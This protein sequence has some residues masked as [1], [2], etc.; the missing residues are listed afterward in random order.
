MLS[1]DESTREDALLLE[2][3]LARN[4]GAFDM[5]FSKY[6]KDIY[7]QAYRML[8]NHEL[9]EDVSQDIFLKVWQKLDMWDANAG[10]F[11]GWLSEV[12]KN[13]IID[14]IRKRNR[15]RKVLLS[16][17]EIPITQHAHPMQNPAR[18]LEA[19]EA[20][21]ML[22][23]ALTEVSNPDHKRAWI[24]RNLD[25]LGIKEIS[26][27]LR[28]KENTIKIWIFRCTKELRRILQRK[29]VYEFC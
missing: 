14:V 11:G 26:K 18:Q 20:Q 10:S 3:A 16:E 4:E 12:A 5:L 1:K 8:R 15:K 27:I 13:A 2:R 9:A 21:Q 22:R 6:R 25:G 24:L 23:Q 28:H 7:R 29:G 17:G 19:K